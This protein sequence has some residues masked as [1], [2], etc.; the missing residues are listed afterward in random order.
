[1]QRYSFYIADQDGKIL[2]EL[3]K[4]SSATLQE[5]VNEITVLN[6]TYPK[7]TNESAYLVPPNIILVSDTTLAT[8]SYDVSISGDTVTFSSLPD[9][10]SAADTI[11]G[12]SGTELHIS[13][14]SGSE[15]VQ[16]L[17]VSGNSV[18]VFPEFSSSITSGRATRNTY[19]RFWIQTRTES[20]ESESVNIAITAWGIESRIKST[21]MNRYLT[22][23]PVAKGSELP[24]DCLLYTSPSP[25]D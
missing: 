11:N 14:D 21:P 7:D 10:I 12:V 17:S 8:D 20:R 22:R 4:V 15:I 24:G 13:Y 19:R 9:W 1:M 6:L 5:R 2:Y 3:D 25:R 16:V 18:T 23:V